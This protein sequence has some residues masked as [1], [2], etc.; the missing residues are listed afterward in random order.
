MPLGNRQ[1]IAIIDIHQYQSRRAPPTCW[2]Q[3]SNTGVIMKIGHSRTAARAMPQRYRSMLAAL[4]LLSGA[5]FHASAAAPADSLSDTDK[6]CLGC[7]GAEGLKK[8]LDN[9]QSLPLHVG[10]DEFANSVHKPI[11]CTGCHSQV[12]IGV[13]PGDVKPIKGLRGSAIA[14]AEICRGCHDRVYRT[15]SG[16]H[17]CRAAPRRYPCGSGVCRLSQA[18]PDKPALGAGRTEECVSRMSHDDHRNA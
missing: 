8:D 11:G 6:A 5:A 18:A 15:L 12:K 9:G 13:H 17:A 4:L 3:A 2:L 16:Q 7:H 1:Q 10:A 14:Q